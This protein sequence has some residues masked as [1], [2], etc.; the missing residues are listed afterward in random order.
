MLQALP[1]WG[2]WQ[3]RLLA[4]PSLAGSRALD[5]FLKAG[6]FDYEYQEFEGNHGSMVPMAWPKVFEFFDR[7]SAR[8][9]AAK[10]S[11]T[12]PR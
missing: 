5:K 2:L 6:K 11:L 12:Q 10:P 1:A 4:E 8:G 7:V 3:P 9:K